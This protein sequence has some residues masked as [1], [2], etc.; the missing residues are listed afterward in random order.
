MIPQ[1][2]GLSFLYLPCDRRNIVHGYPNSSLSFIR[3]KRLS[4]TVMK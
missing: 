4:T 1:I 2:A 3:E